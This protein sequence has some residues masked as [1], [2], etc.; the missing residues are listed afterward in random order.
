[1]VEGESGDVE[2]EIKVEGCAGSE[3]AVTAEPELGDNKA[4]SVVG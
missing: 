4:E 3:H 1:M 2:D